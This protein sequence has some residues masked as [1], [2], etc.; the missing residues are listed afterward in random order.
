[1]PLIDL[2]NSTKFIGRIGVVENFDEW[3]DERVIDG[4]LLNVDQNPC[5]YQWICADG[6]NKP[7]AFSDDEALYINHNCP[8]SLVSKMRFTT[9][10][11]TDSVLEYHTDD[12][13][14]RVDESV[15]GQTTVTSWIGEKLPL[16]EGETEYPLGNDDGFLFDGA[17]PA[18]SYA[19]DICLAGDDLS[20]EFCSRTEA[21]IDG[22][23]DPVD[24][25]DSEDPV[26]VLPCGYTPE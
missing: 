7:F 26:P 10:L 25:V 6:V 22:G 12:T 20:S 13:V 15:E 14:R 5:L 11:Q 4:A 21:P 1:L 17:E 9:V 8:L 19:Y 23:D 16:A 2:D 18:W 3:V 24:P